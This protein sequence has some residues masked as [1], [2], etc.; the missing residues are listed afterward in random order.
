MMTKRRLPIAI[1]ESI[2][3]V[4]V[5]R[6]DLSTD[7]S[8]RIQVEVPKS[9]F[10]V[11]CSAGCAWC[12]HH[13]VVISILEGILI[14]RWMVKQGQWTSRIREKLKESADQQFGTAYHIWMKALIPC[15]LLD[16][17]NRC[18]VYST[19]PLICRAY[20]AISDPHYCHPHRISREHT[21]LLP[22]DSVVEPF[23]A[24]QEK[25]LRRHKLQLINMPIGAALL[26]A[27]KVCSDTVDLEAIDGLLIKEYGERT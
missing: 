13:P 2:G 26:M 4:E 1:E 5:L 17:T 3:K 6:N 20:Y 22:R 23:H 9:G 11:T 14:Y 18:S 19:R 27:E 25:I 7:Y 12:C 8:R 24:E 16:D 21:R 15:P 10:K